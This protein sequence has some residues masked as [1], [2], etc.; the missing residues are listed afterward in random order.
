MKPSHR[1]LAYVVS[2]VAIEMQPAEENEMSIPWWNA[3][4]DM[5]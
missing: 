3:G 2:V 4:P 5:L 1:R